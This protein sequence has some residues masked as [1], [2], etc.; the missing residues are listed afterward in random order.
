MEHRR[1]DGI[2][3]IPAGLKIV[4]YYQS[5]RRMKTSF[6]TAPQTMSSRLFSGQARAVAPAR[7]EGVATMFMQT[8]RKTG[9][10]ALDVVNAVVG[11]CL[12]LSPWVLGF[13]TMG[14]AAW[15]AWIAG[16]LIALVA[17]GALVAFAQWEEW[18]NLILG[19]LAL[20]APWLLGFSSSAEATTVHVAAG[21]IVTVLAAAELWFVHNRSMTS[22]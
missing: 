3:R 11:V 14:M 16:V 20:L 17:I 19:V 5:D 7:W 15:S 13:S 8:N 6:V 18:A 22:A 9:E 1:E 21:L 12:A 2:L 4:L 10:T